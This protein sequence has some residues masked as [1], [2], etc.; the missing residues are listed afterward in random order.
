MKHYQIDIS[1][2]VESQINEVVKHIRL[3]S[4]QNAKAWLTNIYKKIHSLET[5]PNRG[6]LIR[7]HGSFKIEMREILFYSHRIIFTVDEKTS[8]VQVH[9]IRHSAQDELKGIEFQLPRT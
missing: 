9:F 8:K 4:P 2:T 5:M 3:D 6:S 1:P 7:E